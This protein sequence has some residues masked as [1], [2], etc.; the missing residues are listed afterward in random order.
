[1][2]S[3]YDITIEKLPIVSAEHAHLRDVHKTWKWLSFHL[4]A[5]SPR[6]LKVSGIDQ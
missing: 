3:L 2:E 1:M 5:N 4:R 6:M